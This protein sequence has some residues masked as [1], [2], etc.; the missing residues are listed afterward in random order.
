MSI[1]DCLPGQP[2]TVDNPC[3]EVVRSLQD[4]ASV[5]DISGLI[6]SI[7]TVFSA[8]AAVFIVLH[9]GELILGSINR[10]QENEKTER[11]YTH[12]EAINDSDSFQSWRAHKSRH[13]DI[14]EDG[15]IRD[16]D[17]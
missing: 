12:D 2:N 14:D 6:F 9:G 11:L 3:V 16:Y 7:I 13:Y 15:V 4:M 5:M 10:P 17:D 1:P 8:L